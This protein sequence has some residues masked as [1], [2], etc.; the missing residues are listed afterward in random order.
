MSSPSTLGSRARASMTLLAAAMGAVAPVATVSPASGA[1][2]TPNISRPAPQAPQ[3]QGM[4]QAQ[5]I[6]ANQALGIEGGFHG[7]SGGPGTDIH[8]FPAWNQRKA[9]RASRQTG[10]KIQK[11]YKR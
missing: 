2:G 10:R 8:T 5:A 11:R 1:P 6:R 7:F 3:T 4:T 9:R